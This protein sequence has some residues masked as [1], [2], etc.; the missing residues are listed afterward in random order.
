M[1]GLTSVKWRRR[2]VQDDKPSIQ[3]IPKRTFGRGS[4]AWE[5]LLQGLIHA[6]SP[7]LACR[8]ADYHTWIGDP[9]HDTCKFCGMKVLSEE[10]TRE[11]WQE[12]CRRH[13]EYLASNPVY[14]CECGG[15]FCKFPDACKR[16]PWREGIDANGS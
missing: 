14:V 3:T 9:I 7:R 6:V 2:S 5:D 10:T 13:D 4:K 1:A 11:G 16:Q 8:W 15:P 12:M